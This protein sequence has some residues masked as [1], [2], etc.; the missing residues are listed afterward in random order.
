MSPRCRASVQVVLPAVIAMAIPG[1]INW[2][3]LAA[4]ASFS[5][6]SR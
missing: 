5:K 1:R 2:A 3:A 6:I 4:I